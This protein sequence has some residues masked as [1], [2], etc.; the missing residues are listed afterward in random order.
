MVAALYKQHQI[1]WEEQPDPSSRKAQEKQ[2][3]REDCTARKEMGSFAMSLKMCL[4]LSWERNCST[5]IKS[6]ISLG[7]D[8]IKE[9][10]RWP[11]H[12]EGSWTIPRCQLLSSES[13]LPTV[14]DREVELKI[15]TSDVMLAQLILQGM[16]LLGDMREVFFCCCKK[17]KTENSSC[18]C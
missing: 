11:P 17:E 1:Q 16:R 4:H 18:I 2:C 7:V 5:D 14:L 10:L 8:L 12:Y 15:F 9:T 3:Y 6:G 13:F